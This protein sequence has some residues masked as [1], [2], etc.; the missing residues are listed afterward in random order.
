MR[1]GAKIDGCFS[2]NSRFSDLLWAVRRTSSR[3]VDLEK[4]T[5]GEAHSYLLRMN[6][7]AHAR[8]QRL[9]NRAE[10]CFERSVVGCFV[11]GCTGRVNLVHIM[12]E[13]VEW[14]HRDAAVSFA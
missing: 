8:V 5:I 1:V 3:I 11:H 2:R 9:A 7:A 14:C 4:A 12:E 6:N 13:F 10:K